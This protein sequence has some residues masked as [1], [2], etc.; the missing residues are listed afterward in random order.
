MFV[1]ELG[2]ES[3]EGFCQLLF[4]GLFRPVLLG[5]LPFCLLVVEFGIGACWPV[6]F[7]CLLLVAL[8]MLLVLAMVCGLLLSG[9]V[10]TL[11]MLIFM[12]SKKVMSQPPIHVV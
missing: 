1:D 4:V 8:A 9:T 6:L 11:D 2:Q 5:R 7:C 10:L 3:G 12:S